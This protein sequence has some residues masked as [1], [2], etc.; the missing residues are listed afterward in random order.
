MSTIFAE[1]LHQ[2]LAPEVSQPVAPQATWT[3]WAWDPDQFRDEQVRNL[4]RQV[5]LPGWPRP[6]RQVVFCGVGEGDVTEICLSV[7][8]TLAAQVCGNVCVVD[9]NPHV[10][11]MHE[12]EAGEKAVSDYRRCGLLREL[13]QQIAGNLW[14]VP[15]DLFTRGSGQRLSAEWLPGR[16]RELSLEF[17][18]SIINGPAA[19]ISGEGA[20]LGHLSDVII[21]VLRANSTRRIAAQNIRQMLRSAN[22]TLLGVVLDQRRF[23]IPKGIYNKL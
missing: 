13:S 23:P 18:Y 6:A 20:L 21:L 11:S 8:H 12:S 22:A 16:M 4:V 14:R 17:D 2:T 5:F 9:A 3:G 7:A 1:L 19:V 10:T 15:K